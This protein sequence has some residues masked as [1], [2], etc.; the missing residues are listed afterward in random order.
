MKV[1][2]TGKLMNLLHIYTL[3]VPTERPAREELCGS[4]SA[5]TSGQL[6]RAS[7][8]GFV[9][10][11]LSWIHDVYRPVF[12]VQG[13]RVLRR[14]AC[15]RTS[16][17]VSAFSG[18]PHGELRFN[19]II[20]HICIQA[21]FLDDSTK[22]FMQKSSQYIQECEE[23]TECDQYFLIRKRHIGCEGVHEEEEEEEGEGEEEKHEESE[24]REREKLEERKSHLVRRGP[25]V[26]RIH[27]SLVS[28][29]SSQ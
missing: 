13:H 2:R 9:P 19:K 24:T 14:V 21:Q 18:R 22:L 10:L 12:R 6:R 4:N 7:R 16:D 26:E 1:R 20:F 15:P 23:E 11:K 17:D 29:A 27:Q 28:R 25:L 5:V 8:G 3:F